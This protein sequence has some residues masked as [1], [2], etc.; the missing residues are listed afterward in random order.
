M[1]VIER[2]SWSTSS[3]VSVLPVI[4]C[5]VLDTTATEFWYVTATESV[6]VS[7]GGGGAVSGVKGDA[8]STYR[9]G[10]VNLTP[11]NI[12]ALALSGGTMTG[13]L[14]M[15]GANITDVERIY[16]HYHQLTESGNTRGNIYVSGNY[17]YIQ[18]Y[19]SSGTASTCQYRFDLTTWGIA[20]R[21]YTSGAWQSWESHIYN[22]TASRTANTILAAPNGSAGAATFRAL[23]AADIP[24]LA[25]SKITNLGEVVSGGSTSASVNVASSAYAVMGSVVVPTGKWVLFYHVT[26]PSN[27]TG[28][29]WMCIDGTG[30]TSAPSNSYLRT[31]AI[32]VTAVNGSTTALT[33]TYIVTTS[34]ASSTMYLKAWQNS[35]SALAC[36]GYIRAIRIA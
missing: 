34:S 2:T 3:D 24:A 4:P 22:A 6:K 1:R 8:E 35:G 33:G 25:T 19:N 20:F 31:T 36:Y 32:Q 11:A 7:G 9:T 5:F 14:N 28:R 17:L 30:G 23:V 10:T 26:F 15:G 16:A 21:P 27:A 18:G 12:G 29:R 13:V